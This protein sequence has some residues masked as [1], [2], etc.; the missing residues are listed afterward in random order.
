M[1]FTWRSVKFHVQGVT[2]DGVT[3]SSNGI[4]SVQRSV[5]PEHGG[6]LHVL[7]TFSKVYVCAIE[8]IGGVC[9]AVNEHT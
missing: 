5:V 3:V 4:R 6:I 1:P 8:F 2:T 9:H 7:N